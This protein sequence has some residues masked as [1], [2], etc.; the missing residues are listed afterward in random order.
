MHPI[1][2]IWVIF[3]LLTLT[4]LSLIYN[5]FSIKKTLINSILFKFFLGIISLTFILLS[6]EDLFFVVP[7]L[8]T[9]YLIYSFS[10]SSSKK[11]FILKL[12]YIV[13]FW[14][15]VCSFFLILDIDLTNFLL[16]F[17]Y[18]YSYDFNL[19]SEDYILK[20]NN[21]GDGP[22]GSQGSGGPNGGPEGGPQRNG[23]PLVAPQG[24]QDNDQN[25]LRNSILKKLD[26]RRH[27][28]YKK[29]F[30]KKN[31]FTNTID[32]E[33]N[34]TA[35]EKKF[36]TEKATKS[37]IEGREVWDFYE[38]DLGRLLTQE[39]RNKVNNK[40]YYEEVTNNKKGLNDITRW[41]KK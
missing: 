10:N 38:K 11:I 12:S 15:L 23:Q 35:E 3:I 2:V 6:I 36:I 14:H 16:L 33:S 4:L 17:L 21:I 8:L 1:L 31:V 7:I 28:M 25:Q 20:M 39:V 34:F 24:D 26:D 40:S 5:L 13:I 29:N 32:E 30:G 18:N 19:D 22:Q 37:K 41:V 9:G 27:D